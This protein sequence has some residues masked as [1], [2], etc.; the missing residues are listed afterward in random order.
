MVS[1]YRSIFADA[2]KA[3]PLEKPDAPGTG[4]PLR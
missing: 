1:V 2:E 4:E 3:H